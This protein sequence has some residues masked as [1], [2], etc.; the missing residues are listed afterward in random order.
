MKKSG[1]IMIAIL[2]IVL[3]GMN[4]FVYIGKSPIHT[5]GDNLQVVTAPDQEEAMENEQFTVPV[6]D[7]VV[8]EGK[9]VAPEGLCDANGYSDVYPA[10]YANDGSPIGASYWEGPVGEDSILTLNMKKTYH[11]HTLKIAL[12]PATIWAKRTQTLSVSISDDGKNFTEIVP[13]ADY[14]FDPKTGN[15]VVIPIDEV[16]TQYVRLTITKN[17]GASAGQ[18]GELE[19]YTND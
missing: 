6:Y 7:P 17:T 10:T 11:I 2:A 16:N 1:L 15:E 13:S 5:D 19:V 14:V 4:I 9:N 12:N 3:A 8:I 18:V